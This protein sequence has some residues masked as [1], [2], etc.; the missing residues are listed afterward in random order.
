M[1]DA[2]DMVELIYDQHPPKNGIVVN[3]TNDPNG[4][5][6]FIVHSVEEYEQY[7]KKHEIDSLKLK[8]MNS[9]DKESPVLICIM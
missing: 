4:V 6:S 1:R 2:I 7:L 3:I 9:V 5:V 8:V